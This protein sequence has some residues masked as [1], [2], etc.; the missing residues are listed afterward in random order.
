MHRTNY[1][2]EAILQYFKE[3]LFF[4]ILIQY[5]MFVALVLIINVT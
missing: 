1:L 5:V 4:D 2:V 3:L